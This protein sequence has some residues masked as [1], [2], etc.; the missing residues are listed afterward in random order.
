[1]KRFSDWI[2]A[3]GLLHL[4]ELSAWGKAKVEQRLRLIGD[5]VPIVDVLIPCNGEELSIISDTVLATVNL[6]YPSGK[7]RILV[8]DDSNDKAVRDKVKELASNFS[9]HNLFYSTRKKT[10]ARSV[11]AKAG[12]LNH[13]LDFSSRLPGGEGEFVAVLDVDMMPQ[14]H[15]LRTMLAHLTTHPEAA[16]ANP[17]QRFYNIPDD[18]PFT[19]NTSLMF[20]GIEP[21]KSC[22]GASW[23]TGTGYVVRREALEQIKRFPTQNQN[24]DIL[25]SIHLV[26]L[27]WKIIY[28]HEDL[29]WG[30][31]APSVA[32]HLSQRRRWFA[33]FMYTIESMW[34]TH[35]KVPAPI[36]HRIGPTILCF[37]L[38]V[39][40]LVAALS[41]VTVPYLLY[42]GCDFVVFETWS[43]LRTLLFLQNMS[44]LAN[45][46][47]G[48]VR[49]RETNFTCHIFW[50]VGQVGMIPH[51][52]LTFLA[53]F[54]PGP[55]V[56]AITK[57]LRRVNFF[58]SRKWDRKEKSPFMAI[59]GQKSFFAT[60]L[61]VLG[62]CLI[63][64]TRSVSISA[65]HE[66][67]LRMLHWLSHGGYPTL[68]VLGVKYIIQSWIPLSHL[69]FSKQIWASREAMLLRDSPDGRATLAPWAI[70]E[71]RIRP[72][73]AIAIT[74]GL[75]QIGIFIT[76][77]TLSFDMNPK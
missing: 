33:A 7:F 47:S 69:L 42:T 66:G 54:T 41:L 9:S 39:L 12:N 23:C 40:A 16:L 4:Q 58:F 36:S 49:A 35:E 44:F 8:L 61:T 48:Y 75:L 31:V 64:F 34:G 21:I 71:K 15:W 51:Q 68:T 10:T 17:P 20:D 37:Q 53:V 26:A 73:Q 27:G 57:I 24:D 1:M 55:V 29:Q 6:D 5:D 43:Q 13:G 18:D 50:E 19:Q 30:L 67:R 76:A 52:F 60:L 38:V 74:A 14:A 28:V 59:T 77:C 63:G 70:E 22:V 62:V 3:A 72:S 65:S 11:H 25:T 2:V 45:L 46:A 56:D 32:A